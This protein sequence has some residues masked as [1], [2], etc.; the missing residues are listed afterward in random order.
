[1]HL[2]ELKQKS[3]SDLSELARSMKVD[4]AANLRKQ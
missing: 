2:A 3:I 1:M 4:G